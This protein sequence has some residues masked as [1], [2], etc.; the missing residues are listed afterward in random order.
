MKRLKVL[1]VGTELAEPLKCFARRAPLTSYAV[2]PRLTISIT[3]FLD[4][5]RF[6]P[7]RR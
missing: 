2:A 4:R 6:R 5:P 1:G 7:I 3:V